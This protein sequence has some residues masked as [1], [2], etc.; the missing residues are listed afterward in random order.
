MTDMTCLALFSG[1]KRGGKGLLYL[2]QVEKGHVGIYSFSALS[3]F[4]SS[5]LLVLY[6]ISLFLGDNS[7]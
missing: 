5:P 4:L 7:K 6:S 2:K 3:F 1:K